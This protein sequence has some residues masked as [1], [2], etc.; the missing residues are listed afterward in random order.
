MTME[1]QTAWLIEFFGQG[2]PTYYGKTDEGTLGMTGDH[3]L[4][5][6]FARKIDADMV[7][8]DTGWTRPNV[9]AVEHMW[10]GPTLHSLAAK[11]ALR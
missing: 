5:V 9:Q 10:V 4:A 1:D 6:R 3:S 11:T 2:G 7:I 8:D